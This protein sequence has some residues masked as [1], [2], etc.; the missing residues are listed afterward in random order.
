MKTMEEIHQAAVEEVTA[1][2][3]AGEA[4]LGMVSAELLRPI[5]ATFDTLALSKRDRLL[6]LASICA[7]LIGTDEEMTHDDLY[8]IAA[9]GVFR[10][11]IKDSD[12][13][14]A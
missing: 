12:G 3:N 10:D 7:T 5:L 2:L 9:V 14:S 8:Y 4:R 13:T 1:D 11:A 6:V